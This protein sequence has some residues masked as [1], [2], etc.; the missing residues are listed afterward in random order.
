MFSLQRKRQQRNNQLFRDSL[1]EIY[2][3]IFDIYAEPQEVPEDYYTIISKATEAAG[4]DHTSVMANY[5]LLHL[6]E[7][8]RIT[9][10]GGTNSPY[11]C[12]EWPEI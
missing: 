10:I 4:E 3:A 7:Y 6:F 11:A 12:A 1:R 9:K 5:D 8:Y 2:D